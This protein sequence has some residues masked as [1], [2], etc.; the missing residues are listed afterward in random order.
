MEQFFG[1]CLVYLD[2][3]F[4]L[5]DKN[6]LRISDES[7]V[8]EFK[9][10]QIRARTYLKNESGDL[11]A[12]SSTPQCKKGAHH[13]YFLKCSDHESTKKWTSENV[14][15]LNYNLLKPAVFAKW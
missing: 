10:L 3:S 8:K 9:I 4:L 1:Y 5:L 11:V 2:C 14:N 13:Q 15:C 12:S 7:I 6:K